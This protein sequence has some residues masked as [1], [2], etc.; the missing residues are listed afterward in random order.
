MVQAGENCKSSTCG[1]S[2]IR[3][4]LI[5]HLKVVGN[6]FAFKVKAHPVNGTGE[7]AKDPIFG[8]TMGAG[9]QSSSD[10]FR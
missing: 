8:L 4:L 1:L 3:I 2:V 6:L 7:K 5:L 9:S 10:L